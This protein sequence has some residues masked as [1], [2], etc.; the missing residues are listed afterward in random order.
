MASSKTL[1]RRKARKAKARE[2]EL[3]VSARLAARFRS[4]GG[5]GP[6]SGFSKPVRRSDFHVDRTVLEYLDRKLAK[7]G[8]FGLSDAPARL[9]RTRPKSELN[10]IVQWGSKP[11]LARKARHMLTRVPSSTGYKEA[12]LIHVPH[13]D[14][15]SDVWKV[16]S[17][18]TS[19]PVGHRLAFSLVLTEDIAGRSLKSRKGPAA[20]LQDRIA[21]ELR[22]AFPGEPRPAFM[23]M[24]ETT[25]QDWSTPEGLGLHL[26]GV[27]ELPTA[28]SMPRLKRALLRAAGEAPGARRARQLLIRSALNPLG[29]TAY[30]FKHCLTTD[31]AVQTAQAVLHH[32]PAI[33]P[34][35]LIAATSR[36]KAD[37]RGW[38]MAQR[39]SEDLVW[40]ARK[41]AISKKA[42]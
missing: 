38:Y 5:A 16:L 8:Q 36:L 1:K 40:V 3:I 31:R 29:W 21:T 27:L 9:V 4:S 41:S 37:A 42:R 13:W 14:F 30:I 6:L 15:A 39:D 32:P 25:G 28:R 24:L 22:N 19:I 20:Y 17:Y 23:M 34:V 35:T 11:T 10:K 12:Y 7:G 33:G 2:E 18:V 26:H